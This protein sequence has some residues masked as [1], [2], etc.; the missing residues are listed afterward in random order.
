[1]RMVKFQLDDLKAAIRPD[2]IIISIMA[3]NNEIGTIEPIKR[4]RCRLPKNK[5]LLFHTDAV[6]AFGHIPINVDE[7]DIDMLSASGHKINGPKGIGIFI[8]QK[9]LKD[10]LISFMAVPRREREEQVHIMFRVLWV[11]VRQQLLH[12]LKWQREVHM[13]AN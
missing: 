3:A 1:M 4:N 13:N 5:E 10:R 7:M 8:Y 12:L 2:T 9:R 6:Q 11:L